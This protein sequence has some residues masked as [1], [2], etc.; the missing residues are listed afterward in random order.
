MSST[1][2]AGIS[3][4]CMFGG[5]LLGLGLQG[6]LPS[7]DLSESQDVVKLGAGVI[8]T[9]TAL[10][11]GLLVSSAKSTLDHVTSRIIQFSASIVIVDRMLAHY[12]PEAEGAREQLRQCTE[13]ALFRIWPSK[14]SSLSGIVAIE[15]GG[16]IETIQHTLRALTPGTNTQRELLTQAGQVMNE[17]A[18]SHWTLIEEAQNQLPGPLLVMLVVWLTLLFTSFGL[19]APKNATIVAVLF[20]CAGS[21]AA[22][23]FL[24]LEMNRPFDGFIRV[25]SAPVRKA[26]ESLGR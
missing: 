25:S 3:A 21:M 18:Q 17:V 24:V 6:L 1:L 10:V 26:L 7:H 12:G 14:R 11:L 9:L 23:I 8:A 19:F 4:A 15:R 16:E 22:A 20:L 13:T 5:A 2:I